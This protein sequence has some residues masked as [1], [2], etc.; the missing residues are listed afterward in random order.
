MY[1]TKCRIALEWEERK[2]EVEKMGLVQPKLKKDSIVVA[3][4]E[5]TV[6]ASKCNPA[7]CGI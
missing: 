2:V 1:W 6:T 5:E 7:S 4:G 3:E